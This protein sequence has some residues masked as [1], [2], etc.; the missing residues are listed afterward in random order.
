MTFVEIKRIATERGIKVG[1]VKKADIVR[2]I[3]NQEGNVPCFATGKAR[4]CG[5]VHCLWVSACE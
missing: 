3:Q 5:Q 1:G 2:S 4:E